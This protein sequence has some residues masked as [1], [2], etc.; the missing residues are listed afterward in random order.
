MI[1]LTTNYSEYDKKKILR[2]IYP[3]ELQLNESHS[4]DKETNFLNLNPK[5]IVQL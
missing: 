4:C 5:A 3:A 2:N 1:C